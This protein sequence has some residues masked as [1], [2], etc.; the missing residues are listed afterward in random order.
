MNDRIGLICAGH[1]VP[2]GHVLT[3]SQARQDSFEESHVPASV[4]K[5]EYRRYF[6]GQ[7]RSRSCALPVAPSLVSFEHDPTGNTEDP[8]DSYS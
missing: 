6:T 7:S 8:T 2:D 5:E 1:E 4:G 3:R